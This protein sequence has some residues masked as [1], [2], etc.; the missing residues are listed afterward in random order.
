MTR[1]KSSAKT[2]APVT[3]SGAPTA[4]QAKPAASAK[5][6]AVGPTAKVP[7]KAAST[8][9]TNGGA[10]SS[11]V[12]PKAK[13]VRDSFTIPKSEYSVLEGLKFRA[14]RLSRPVKKS[15]L[16]RAGIAALNSMTDKAFL[17]VLSGVP[18]LKTGR[19]KASESV[20]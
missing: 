5:R 16:L 10:V 2:R 11:P 19:P 15:E 14:A 13:L 12:E 20:G 17:A 3:T 6:A 9:A 7:A 18:S 4:R 1:A 8:R